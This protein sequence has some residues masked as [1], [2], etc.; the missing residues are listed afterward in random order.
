MTVFLSI[1][2]G[3]LC[4]NVWLS[5][6]SKLCFRLLPSIG[7]QNHQT[8]PVILLAIILL[9]AFNLN[10]IVGAQGL[11]VV[12]ALATPLMLLATWAYVPRSE[13]KSAAV[14]TLGML[15]VELVA[16]F[17]VLMLFKGWKFWLHEGPNH[18]SLVYF[19]GMSWAIDSPL[20]IDSQAVSSRWGLGKC[21][22]GSMWIGNNCSLYRGGTYSLAAWTQFF[23]PS[24]SGVWTSPDLVD[25]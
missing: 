12:F 22:E 8:R 6:G 13:L 11:F 17:V 18:D 16:L 3:I 14:E 7:V 2:V 25:S 23:S 5:F 9:A 4:V 21:G 15:A 1:L 20:W 19:E 24:K 10:L